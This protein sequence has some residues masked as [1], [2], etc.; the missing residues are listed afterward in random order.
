M[1]LHQSQVLARLNDA[2]RLCEKQVSVQY[3]GPSGV[4]INSGE[5]RETGRL[6]HPQLV[7]GMRNIVMSFIRIRES[8][9]IQHY[10]PFYDIVLSL[11]HGI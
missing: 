6:H 7:S 9:A 10:L 1:C 4:A 2:R 3:L 5:L 11:Q 8:N